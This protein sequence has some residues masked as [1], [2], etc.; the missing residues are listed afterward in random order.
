MMAEKND[1]PK[2]GLGRGLDA[3]FGDTELMAAVIEPRGPAEIHALRPQEKNVAEQKST[4]QKENSLPEKSDTAPTGAAAG[5]RTLPI[6]ALTPSKFQPRTFFDETQ[7]KS[8]ADSI[9]N[10]GI[11]QPILVRPTANNTYEI[12]AGE[13]RWRAAQIAQLHDVPVVIQPM[14]DQAALEIALIE[15]IQ[16]QDLSPIE[17]AEGYHRLMIEFK[18]TQ[19]ELA[20]ILGKSRS[21]IANA[22][23][24][25]QLP[26]FA[27]EK[28]HTGKISAGHARQM[29]G[30]EDGDIVRLMQA[31]IQD[32]MSVR[33]IEKRRQEIIHRQNHW[34]VPKAPKSG[35]A[36]GVAVAKDADVIALEKE[37]GNLLGLAVAIDADD[38]GKGRLSVAFDS[39]DQLDD[40]LQKLTRAS[41]A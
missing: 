25:L 34:P 2:R 40:L 8:L 11:V 41:R 5:Q 29:I 28:V 33:G 15:N 3:L 23:R 4:E 10:H 26:D 6:A 24:L 16:R 19:E 38:K 39:L 36:P 12:I 32:G 14:N 35:A 1:K 22:L 7:L 20:E 17:E 9:K 13:R 21:A 27:R 31:V 30:L 18:H 37:M